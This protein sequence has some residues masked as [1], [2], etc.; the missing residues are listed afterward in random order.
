M[1][2]IGPHELIRSRELRQVCDKKLTI[3]AHHPIM[4]AAKQELN[5]EKFRN[6]LTA[7][8]SAVAGLALFFY[9]HLY[10]VEGLT[11][12]R[13]MQAESPNVAQVCD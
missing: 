11:L 7:V 2:V 3:M 10:P 6:T 4:C 12:L 1:E 8:G 13:R 5:A 9:Q